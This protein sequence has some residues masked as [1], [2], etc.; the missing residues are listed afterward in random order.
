MTLP[1]C[2]DKEN[3][4]VLDIWLIDYIQFNIADLQNYRGIENIYVAISCQQHGVEWCYF[5]NVEVKSI[6]P[7]NYPLFE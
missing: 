7:A 4:P 1:V 5:P 3:N 2:S 6:F